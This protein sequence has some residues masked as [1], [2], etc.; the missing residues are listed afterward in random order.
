[1][2]EIRFVDTTIRDGHQSLWAE[3]MTTGMML[4]VADRLDDAGFDA[5]ELLS[6]S[7]VKKAVRELKEDPWERIRLV[8]GRITRTPLRVIVGRVKTFEFNPRCMQYLFVK[9]MA[10]AGIRQARISDEWNNLEGWKLKVGLCREVGLEPVLNLIYSV[11]PK[12]TPEYYAERTRQ[13]A[14][15]NVPRLCLKDPGGL[16]TPDST[17][18]LVPVI[19]ENAGGIPVEIHTHCTTGLGPLNC[20][21]AMQLGITIINTAL[22]P[23][24]DGSSLPSLFNVA[25]NARALGH[26]PVIDLESLK[27]VSEQLTRIAEREGFPIGRPSEYRYS[28]YLHQVPGGM[29]SNLGHQLEVVGLG[30]RLPEALEETTRVRRDLGY[31]IMVTPLSQFVGSQAAINVIAGEPYKEVTDQV[32]KYALGQFGSEAAES[33][34]PDVKDK[35]LDRP[36]ARELAEWKPEELTLEEMR[37]KFGGPGTS[38]EELMLRWLLTEEEI[39]AMRAAPAPEEYRVDRHPLVTLVAELARRKDIAHI[40]VEKPGV[41]VML[42]RPA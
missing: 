17:R 2:S 8:A 41:S 14:S 23:L 38:D 29:I 3:S 4:S 18:A 32:I 36:R 24:S 11:S 25:E 7:H 20:L 37:G 12:H 30:D 40:E 39:A 15:L 27:P 21:E 33:M 16:L 10:D 31:P 9:C 1:M 42:N 26:D 34:D 28:Q 5:I 19:L 13:A 35:V 6:G 22:P